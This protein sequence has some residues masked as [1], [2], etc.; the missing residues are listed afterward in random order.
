MI[1]GQID[2][3]RFLWWCDRH[4]V[5]SQVYDNLDAAARR[6]LPD[7]VLH[8]LRDQVLENTKHA[9]VRSTELVNLLKR[10]RKYGIHAIS[11]K[12]TALSLSLYGDLNLRHAGDIDLLIAP[13]HFEGA[14]SLLQDSGY[15]NI[16]PGSDH[17]DR[18]RDLI[19]NVGY[20][21]DGEDTPETHRI[22]LE[23]HWRLTNLRT[24]SV[25]FGE[26]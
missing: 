1:T 26:L 2:W 19:S 23:L 10:F 6:T 20:I 14:D 18:F 8:D 16:T 17:G 7:T 22:Q 3:K 11:L 24:F 13:E 12:G 15:R 5:V 25:P 4:K 9:V 21:L